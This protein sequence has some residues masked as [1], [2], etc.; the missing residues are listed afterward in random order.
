MTNKREQASAFMDWV[1]KVF[2]WA[3]AVLFVVFIMRSC[4]TDDKILLTECIKQ[5]QT[6]MDYDYDTAARYC[7]E[8]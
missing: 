7:L 6:E 4:V 3:A 8:Q 2:P 1:G 5:A